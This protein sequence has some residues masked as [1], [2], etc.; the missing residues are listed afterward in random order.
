MND[1]AGREYFG[2]ADDAEQVV[3]E[4][5]LDKVVDVRVNGRAGAGRLHIRS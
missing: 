4:R 5:S 2:G 1:I 3:R